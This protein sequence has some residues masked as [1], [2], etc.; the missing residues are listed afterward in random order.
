M[1]GQV[2]SFL[3]LMKYC[4]FECPACH[5]KLGTYEHGRSAQVFHRH[6]DGEG[7]VDVRMKL[8]EERWV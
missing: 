1:G 5:Y 2:V 3:V 8:V 6:N 4:V 7:M